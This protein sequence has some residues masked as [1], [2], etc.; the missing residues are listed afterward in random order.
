MYSEDEYNAATNGAAEDLRRLGLTD[1]QR[2]WWDDYDN[3]MELGEV[4]NDVRLTDEQ[5]QV[6]IDA[7]FSRI[8][9]NH[10][11]GWETYYTFYDK[12][13]ESLKVTEGWRKR[14]VSDSTSETTRSIGV[15]IED[16]DRGYWEVDRYPEDWP[17]NRLDTGYFRIV[18]NEA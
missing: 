7:G 3:S 12:E 4:G 1:F 2:A 11:D 10:K 14:W 9:L 16:A 8:W 13:T 17:Q 6:V 5:Q 18:D 15:N